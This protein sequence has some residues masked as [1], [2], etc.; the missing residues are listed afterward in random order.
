MIHRISNATGMNL[1][2]SKKCLAENGWIYD[3]AIAAFKF[4]QEQG[5]IPFEAFHR[6]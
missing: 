5:K 6:Q 2:Y 1:E 3:K 4:I